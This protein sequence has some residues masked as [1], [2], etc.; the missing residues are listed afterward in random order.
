MTDG[1]MSDSI[2]PFT[3]A[4]CG[5]RFTLTAPCYPIIQ[6]LDGAFRPAEFVFSAGKTPSVREPSEKWEGGASA[7]PETYPEAI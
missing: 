4:E 5:R 2:K 3:S 7:P 1:S 6:I